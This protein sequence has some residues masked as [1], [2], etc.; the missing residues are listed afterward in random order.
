MQN[1]NITSSI[2]WINEIIEHTIR[3]VKI[4]LINFFN[5]FVVQLKTTGRDAVSEVPLA[6]LL[7]VLA[8]WHISL[9]QM[10]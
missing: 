2:Y 4:I 7:P 9:C 6:V 5:D 3:S 8:S 1:I 10:R